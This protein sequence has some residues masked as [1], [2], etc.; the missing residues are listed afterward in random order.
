MA[1]DMAILQIG[2]SDWS[3]EVP[4]PEHMSWFYRPADQADLS[5]LEELLEAEELKGFTAVIAESQAD[6][7][8]LSRL[9]SLLIPYS[10]FYDQDLELTDE[11]VADFVKQICA[12]PT[13]FSDRA[14]LLRI[15]SK[16]LF[17]GQYGDKLF[18]FQTQVHPSFQGSVT[19][20]G[21]ESVTLEGDFG[22]D[23]R[24][25]LN[26]TY[27][28]RASKENPIELWLEFE[29][30]GPCDC[31]LTLKIIP[32]GS[33]SDVVETI[34]ASEEEMRQGALVLDQDRTYMLAISLQARGEGSLKI[35]SL[36]QRLTR[37]QFGKYVLGGGILHDDKRQEVNYFF[38]PGD[39]KPPLSVYFSGFRPA[40]GFEG[41][42]MMSSMGTPFLL[43]SD[44]R[45]LG[46]AFYM[47]SE[48]L[49]GQ[50]QATI[51]HYLDYLGFGKEQLILSGMSMG[52][53][54]SLYYGADFEPHAI[55]TSKPLANIG[56]IGQRARLLA[57]EV[58]PTGVDVLHLQTGG[59]TPEAVNQLNQKFWDKFQ[60]A[61]FSQTTFG[62]S[63]MKD[64]DMDPTA[65]ADVTQ[66]LYGSGAKIL[67]KGTSGRH[68][69]DSTTAAN[70][71]MNFY[72][73][74]LEN[75]FGRKG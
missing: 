72:Q 69:D 67:S 39:F 56:T 61:D 31:Q 34:L 45:L 59:L 20:Q 4:L 18:P 44:P 42:G 2:A 38:Y 62:F 15:F 24:S 47:G 23:F 57:P 35:G 63:Y 3:Q 52:T 64:E 68:N 33:V 74:V 75:D 22:P 60:Q 58:F 17:R 12:V 32:E 66:A 1:K 29:K 28:I 53:Y 65:Y 54:P 14:E 30:D 10:V 50:I 27:N 40:E 37:Y 26:W 55:I 16:A 46:G 11:A 9:S 36:H 73:M 5:D 43:F 71:F 41:F 70:W 49:E 48:E 21:H 19:Y 51:Q 13:D 7:L 25:V 8:A 6:L